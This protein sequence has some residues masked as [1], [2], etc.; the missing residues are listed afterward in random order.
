MLANEVTRAGL[1]VGT[2]GILGGQA[3][4]PQVEGIWKVSYTLSPSHFVSFLIT[5]TRY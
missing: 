4:M 3:Y 5:S 2:E 1:E